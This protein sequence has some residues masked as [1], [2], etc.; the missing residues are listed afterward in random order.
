MAFLN[1]V[2]RQLQ[3]QAPAVK[4]DLTGKTVL[5]LGANTGLG[6]EAV[7]HF[8]SMN[9]GRL[10]LACRSQ[11][12][13]K[14]A[15]QKL[16]AETNYTKAELWLVDLANF[17]SVTKFADKFE[18]DGG[19]LDI[20]V[21]NAAV[22][23]G[24]YEA[25]KDGWE[26]SLQV[27]CISTPLVALRLL[28][29][30][31]KTAHQHST[32][33]RVVVVSSSVHAQ[34][35]IEKGV[36]EKP[37][38]FKTLG[39]SEYCTKKVMESRYPLT[40]LLNVFFV[41]ALNARVPASMQLIVNNV[42]PGFCRSELSRRATGMQAVMFTLMKA[43]LAFSPEVGSRRLVWAAVAQQD[44][45]DT[46]RGQYITAAKV[47]LVSDFVQSPQG[48]KVQDALWDDLLVVLSK[49]D[50]KVTAIVDTYLS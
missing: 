2:A 19:R 6:F 9:P 36:Y 22:A 42:D 21:A 13:G 10:I 23:I 48:I 37:H 17:K 15:L 33:P 4:V 40:K 44:Q 25:T 30:M 12:R 11:S 35:E 29:T 16:K 31:I 43:A 38:M 47:D 24:E 20:L 1:F 27:N 7:K 45:P 18:Q 46:L 8:A 50:P 3:S 26:I 34:V 39:S 32:V 49:V 14:A 28:P 41:R 5:V